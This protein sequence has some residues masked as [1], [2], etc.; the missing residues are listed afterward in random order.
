MAK[1]SKENPTPGPGRRRLTPEQKREARLKRAAEYDFKEECRALLP[2]ATDQ[3]LEQLA[4]KKFKTGELVR[5]S[6]MLR[7]SVH[8]KPAQT[9]QGP[10]GG[11]LVGSF[12]MLLATVDGAKVEKLHDAALA[13]GNGN[14]NGN[15]SHEKL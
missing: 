3:L 9:L 11:P 13:H 2:I 6:E 15:G 8:G 14:G 1:F 4:A 12:T 10:G 7:D 5:V